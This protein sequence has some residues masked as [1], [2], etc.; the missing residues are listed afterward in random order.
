MMALLS[1]SVDCL[2]ALMVLQLLRAGEQQVQRAHV[3]LDCTEII[4]TAYSSP[5]RITSNVSTRH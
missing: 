1:L 4:S 2:I 3:C 5:P